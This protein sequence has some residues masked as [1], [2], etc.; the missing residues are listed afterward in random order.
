MRGLRRVPRDAAIEALCLA[1]LDYADGPVSLET[2]AGKAELPKA[3]IDAVRASLR[4][5][6][7]TIATLCALP[8]CSRATPSELAA[9][10]IGAE[11]A[12]PLWQQPGEAADWDRAAASARRFNA[13]AAQ[14]LAPHGVGPTR[15]GLAS[16][17][18]GGGLGVSGLELAV[19]WLGTRAM[20]QQPADRIADV[21]NAD[22]L[23]RQLLPRGQEPATEVL[24]GLKRTVQTLLVQKLP[25]WRALGMV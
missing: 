22:A 19:V 18:L 16:P 4:T 6:P 9:L 14:R 8:A 15:L 23:V 24:E 21:W 12:V 10:L 20:T 11:V 17:A 25:A 3:L 2:Q 1:A 13:V 5:G 7:K